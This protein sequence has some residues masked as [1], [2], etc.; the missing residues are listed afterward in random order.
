MKKVIALIAAGSFALGLP[1]FAGNPN[2]SA[3]AS[4]DEGQA[5]R[6]A[7]TVPVRK[8]DLNDEQKKKMAEIMAEHHK[9]GCT[10]ASEAK[11]VEQVKGILTPDQFAKFKKSYEAGPK[12]KM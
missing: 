9:V 8:F 2:D 6:M 3:V 4:Q 10:P 11:F 12:M 1:A 7:C 5:F